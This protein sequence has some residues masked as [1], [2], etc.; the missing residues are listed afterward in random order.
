MSCLQLLARARTLVPEAV[1]TPE[2]AV[3]SVVDVFLD[4][5]RLS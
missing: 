5:A 4:G 1:S 3:E 2:A